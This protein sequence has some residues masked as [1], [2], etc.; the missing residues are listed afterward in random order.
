V[1]RASRLIVLGSIVLAGVAHGWLASWQP[2]LA[3]TAAAAFVIAFVLARL[4][5]RAALGAVL[6][7]AFVAPALL[8]VGFG[9]NDYHLTLVWLAALAG[10]I[11]AHV[12][13]ARWHLPRGWSIPFVAWALIVAVSWPIVAGREIDF[14]V[15]A[16]RSFD[17]VNV[18]YG[19]PPP[20]AAAWIV[21]VALGQMLGIVWFDTLWARFAAGRAWQFEEFILVPLLAS[22]VLSGAAA[23]YQ[24][25][26]DL[27]WLNPGIWPRQQRAAGLMLDANSLGILAA[28]WGPASIALAWRLK[29][30]TWIAVATYLLLAAAMWTAG[31][32]TALLAM[33]VGTV[34]VMVGVA[35]RK[36]LWQPRL[37]PIALLIG[38]AAVVLAMAL[39]PRGGN[40]AS[41]LQR[42]FDRLPRPEA[43]E[44]RRFADEMWN[45]F[46]YGQV[47]AR[48]I[49]EHPLT[50]VGTG[51]FH[52]VAADY[53]FRETRRSLAADNAQNWWRHQIAELG[54]LG[55]LPSLWISLMV[56]GL[57]WRGSP[58][59]EPVTGSALDIPAEP[60]TTVLR[61]VL[62]GVGLASMLGVPTQHPAT[63]LTFVTLL[64]W[65]LALPEAESDATRGQ[66]VQPHHHERLQF[67]RAAAIVLALV[68]ATGQAVTA[69]G[70][71]RVP[72]RALRTHIPYS[73]GVSQPEGL[74]EYGELRWVAARAV[75]VMPVPDRWLQLTMWAPHADVATD[76][77][78]V[79]IWVTPRRVLQHALSSQEPV[80]YF[81]QIPEGAEWT[82]LELS[83]S[84]SVRGPRHADSA[85]WGGF[86]EGR[87]IQIAT[88]WHRDVPENVSAERIIR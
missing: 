42:M 25:L 2:G 39:A 87:A 67:W 64:F 76:P 43:G 1:E 74:S 38:G 48:V 80:S 30:P 26:F 75:G 7:T 5:L 61:T 66:A 70:D 19:Q 85:W 24:S 53:A 35:Q 17:T 15:V 12:D 59:I 10:V 20:A 65:L 29:W 28:M 88:K 8:Y 72:S 78:I 21:V 33:S 57:L 51:A 83:A 11:F 55:A 68:V 4:W 37:A 18:L 86:R 40:S 49:A 23:L 77:V 82:M 84:R 14:S 56:I 52:V 69:V 62:I 6:G 58:Y 32:R 36:G 63:W 9:V 47:A 50:G 41:P 16:A 81:L 73:Y 31:S 27:E 79:E 22:V 54:L 71:L 34:G 45:R 44:I 3:P 60:V 46:G 13:V